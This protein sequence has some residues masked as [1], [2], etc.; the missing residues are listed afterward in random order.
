M[1]IALALG[2]YLPSF[3]FLPQETFSLLHKI[4]I[5]FS[6]LLQGQNVESG[7]ALP[8]FEG[9]REKPSTTEKVRMRGVVLRTRNIVVETA[10]KSAYDEETTYTVDSVTDTERGLTTDDDTEMGDGE[11]SN[12]DERWEMDIARVYERTIASLGVTLDNM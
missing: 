6:S 2:T 12:E 4:D 11:D 7:R 1:T 5:A 10:G 8:G 3:A 9:G